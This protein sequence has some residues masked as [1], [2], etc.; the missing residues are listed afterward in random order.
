MAAK[1]QKKTAG[2]SK[3]KFKFELNFYRTLSLGAFVVLAMVWSFILG[4]FVGRGYNPED[5]IPDIAR[6]LPDSDRESSAPRILRP[7]EL[8]FFD[9][10]RSAPPALRTPPPVQEKTTASSQPQP[11]VQTRPDP[12]AAPA[13][14]PE[15]ETYI[16]SYQ[17]GSFQKMQSAVELRKQLMNEGFSASIADAFVNN[18]PWFRVIVEFQSS[19]QN[20]RRMMEKLEAHG[21]TQPVF[22]GR[23]PS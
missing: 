10:L 19:E 22:R 9:R 13:G 8:E 14:V 4:V 2:K 1:N 3:N 18:E 20:S 15:V 16:Y 6:I 21:I 17:V 11:T 5:V 12:P 23:R 7:E